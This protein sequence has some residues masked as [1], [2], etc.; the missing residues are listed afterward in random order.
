MKK[1]TGLTIVMSLITLVAMACPVCERNQSSTLFSGWT[2]GK[3]PAGSFDYFIVITMIVIALLS[4]IFTIRWI[5]KPG[6][7]NEGH[8][9][10]FI[11]NQ[12][13]DESE[14]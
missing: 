5:Y 2:H 1:H 11:L 12:E 3:S 13:H 8:I 4:L 10:R 9:K 14:K 6:E 7:K